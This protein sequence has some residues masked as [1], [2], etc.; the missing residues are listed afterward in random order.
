[1]HHNFAT[2]R[3]RVMRFGFVAKCPERYCL[4]DKGYKCLNVLQLASKVVYLK[5]KLTAKS[6]RQIHGTKF[7]LSSLSRIKRNGAKCVDRRMK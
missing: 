2:V 3:H 7:T 6:L 1:M 4:H 5:K